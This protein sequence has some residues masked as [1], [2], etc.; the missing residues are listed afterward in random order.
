MGG[1]GPDTLSSLTCADGQI[2]A[3][4]AGSTA[5]EC[6][7]GS[8]ADTLAGLFCTDGQI[9]SWDAGSSAW[10]CA[11]MSG[12]GDNPD[13]T[14]GLVSRWALA[15]SSGTS[16]PDSVG[17]NNGTLANGPVWQPTSGQIDGALQFDGSNDRVTI[18]HN[19]TLNFGT[20]DFSIGGWVKGS[21]PLQNDIYPRLYEKFH[22]GS[23]TGINIY[24]S[25]SNTEDFPSCEYV[26]SGTY[27]LARAT[28]YS[29]RDNNWHHIMCVKDG[30]GAKIYVDG[31]E[32]GSYSGSIGNVNTTA[33]AS[34]G[35]SRGWDSDYY[36]GT[37]DDVRVYNRALTPTEITT[38]Y[39][40][41][42]GGGS[43]GGS[44][45]LAGLSCSSGQVAKW[46]GSTTSPTTTSV[47]SAT[48]GA[49]NPAGAGQRRVLLHHRGEPRGRRAGQPCH[50]IFLDQRQPGCSG[51]HRF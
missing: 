15:E 47:T 44:D 39:N 26:V 22:T 29:V 17:S 41:D 34:I 12:G 16:A 23:E 32:R 6:I 10:V 37:I 8:N 50:G 42:G 24:T 45:T 51:Y 38:L 21:Y 48:D 13:V 25:G 46:N 31:V 18:P 9:P 27:R 35:W 2:V 11:T 7:D 36:Q 5:W 4:N 28:G 1:G 43:G 49:G 30:S 40:Y 19:A 3:W 14:T 20:G 33:D